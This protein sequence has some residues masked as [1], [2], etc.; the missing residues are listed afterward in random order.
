MKEPIAKAVFVAGSCLL[1]LGVLAAA[2]G[3]AWADARSQADEAIRRGVA[4]RKAGDDEAAAREFQKAHD[5]V[6][7][8][9]AAAQLGLA[10]QALGRWED[11][12]SHISEALHSPEDSW[13]SKNRGALEHALGYVKEHVG[14]VEVVGEPEG[15]EVIVNGRAAGKLPLEGPVRVSAGQVDIEVRAPG[16]PRATRALTITGG[17]YQRVVIRLEKEAPPP[18][19][20]RAVAELP[21]PAE[22]PARTEPT[23]PHPTGYTTGEPAAGP[24]TGRVVAKWTALGLAA[25]GLVTGAT[26]ALIHEKKVS[27][28]DAADNMGCADNGGTAVHRND[29]SPAPECQGALNAYRSARTWEIV[30]FSAGGALAAT[31]LVLLLTE[32]SSTQANEKGSVVVWACAPSLLG[33]GGVGCALRF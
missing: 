15:A 2:G 17:Q 26:A 16:Y 28:F 11:A 29:G 5:L 20:P 24:S 13:V 19:P 27:D 25:A 33:A 22:T 18:A 1:V 3:P 4:L 10:E 6:P 21:H 14:R 31:W 30:G 32:P 9:R 7:S 8:P 12:E 23:A